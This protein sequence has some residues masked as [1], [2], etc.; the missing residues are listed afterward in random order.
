MPDSYG[1]PHIFPWYSRM[2]R[3]KG[4]DHP[5]SIES[6]RNW[7]HLSRTDQV[8]GA[9]LEFCDKS[10]QGGWS[11]EWKQILAVGPFVKRKRMYGSIPFV[12]IA[13]YDYPYKHLLNISE[14]L[15]D[16]FLEFAILPDLHIFTDDFAEYMEKTDNREWKNTQRISIPLG[17]IT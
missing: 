11:S 17:R 6:L 9:Y 1:A 10:L 2:R 4:I 15:A 14:V 13:D 12:I 8:H 7:P 16:A 3:I 5:D